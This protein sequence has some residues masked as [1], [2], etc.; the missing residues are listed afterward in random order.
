VDHY[1]FY[2]EKEKTQLKLDWQRIAIMKGKG[3]CGYLMMN[4]K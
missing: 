1:A 4:M 3:G 2:Y